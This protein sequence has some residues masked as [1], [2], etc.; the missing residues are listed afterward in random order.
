MPY[1]IYIRHID[2]FLLQI[3]GFFFF[4]T[5]LYIAVGLG[6]VGAFIE[7]R[8]HACAHAHTHARTHHATTQ[9]LSEQASRVAKRAKHSRRFVAEKLKQKRLKNEK[10]ARDRAEEKGARSDETD[11]KRI[12]DAIFSQRKGKARTNR[13]LSA[14]AT[15]AN[16]LLTMKSTIRAT[17][18]SSEKYDGKVG[19]GT[20]MYTP[21]G[22]PG[23]LQKGLSRKDVTSGILMSS[24]GEYFAPA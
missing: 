9:V 12:D 1:A 6:I 11:L 17:K 20:S 16:K 4:I 22:R 8:T 23:T 5:V 13:F 14:T 15:T 19:P 21:R 10:R 3:G 7:V 18:R 2:T 24:D